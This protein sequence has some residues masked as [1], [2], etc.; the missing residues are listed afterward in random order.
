MPVFAATDPSTDIG[1]VI[2]KG[3][4]G[5]WCESN[6]L[7]EYSRILESITHSPSVI[8]EKGKNAKKYL[9]ENYSS[10]TTCETILEQINKLD[11]GISDFPK[12]V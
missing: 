11:R 1:E 9:T 2:L 5:W 6:D 7:S 4:F 8:Q 10:S 3:D 12:L